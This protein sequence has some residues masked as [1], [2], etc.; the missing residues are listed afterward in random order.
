MRSNRTLDLEAAE[1]RLDGQLE[2]AGIDAVGAVDEQSVAEVS[3]G[4]VPHLEEGVDNLLDLLE[5]VFEIPQPHAM[6]PVP[7]PVTEL[8]EPGRHANGAADL[9]RRLARCSGRDNSADLAAAQLEAVEELAPRNCRWIT[10]HERLCSERLLCRL[11]LPV[12]RELGPDVL[13]AVQGL[14]YR[15]AAEV[16]L[17][18]FEITRHVHAASASDC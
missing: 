8:V 3:C 16:A 6:R 9:E 13:R 7:D 15:R 17:N 5:V 14:A 11:G 4:Q 12:R 1:V 2:R 18:V 10:P